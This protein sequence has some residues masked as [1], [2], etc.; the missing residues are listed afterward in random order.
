MEVDI[1][2]FCPEW[3]SRAREAGAALRDYVVQELRRLDEEGA[4]I[5]RAVLTHPDDR[6]QALALQALDPAFIA[7]D[8][9]PAIQPRMWFLRLVDG[10]EPPHLDPQGRPLDAKDR[11]KVL[12]AKVGNIGGNNGGNTPALADIRSCAGVS[13]DNRTRANYARQNLYLTVDITAQP[14]AL[15]LAQAVTILRQW[16]LGVTDRAFR[17]AKR[18]HLRGGQ[19]PAEHGQSLWLV[20]EV[21]PQD[22]GRKPRKSAAAE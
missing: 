10:A 3:P 16:G 8:G 6:T 2:S 14:R 17:S 15:P 12:R 18:S 7:P 19:E 11:G 4:P 1:P 20:E 21:N 13:G 9:S 5:L 22:M